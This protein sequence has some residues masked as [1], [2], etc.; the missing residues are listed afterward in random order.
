[1]NHNENYK[2]EVFR[3]ALFLGELMMSNGSETTRVED[4][5]VRVCKSR[6]F[7]HVTVFT[8]PTSLIIS[9]SR[10]DG[11]T[12]MITIKDRMI[13]LN[14]IDLFNDFS[15]RFVADKDMTI[16]DALKELKAIN[17]KSYFYPK[18]LRYIAVGFACASS[19]ALIGG[20]TLTNFVLTFIT[21]MISFAIYNKIMSLNPI[22]AFASLVSA[23][24]IGLCGIVVTQLGFVESATTLI[25][26]SIMPLLSG[27]PFVKGIRDL[28]CGDLV[29]GLARVVEACIATAAT[30]A[31][32]G[33]VLDFWL[34]L[35]GSI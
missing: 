4:T 28:I 13:D 32:V 5:V 9:D 29:S 14:K 7:N 35:G 25:V 27:V 24:I 19:G 20:N 3:F 15:R 11:L 1:M 17:K 12:F 33:F 6:G 34:R 10:F 30:S 23:S 8:S 16:E 18:Y 26:G 2:K 21:S 22:S 31:G